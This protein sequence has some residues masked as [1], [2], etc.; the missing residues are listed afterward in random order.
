M[1]LSIITDSPKFLS[2]WLKPIS[3]K[4]NTDSQEE[5]GLFNPLVVLGLTEL[6]IS[7]GGGISGN[8]KLKLPSLL[9][10]AKG[11]ALAIAGWVH[12]YNSNSEAKRKKT[13]T[14][15]ALQTKRIAKVAETPSERVVQLE[16][17]QIGALIEDKNTAH[18]PVTNEEN[19]IKKSLEEIKLLEEKFD[20]EKIL[21]AI[22]KILNKCQRQQYKNIAEEAYLEIF[23]IGKKLPVRVLEKAL[24]DKDMKLKRW[25]ML[26]LLA[27]ENS[28][29]EE[30]LSKAIKQPENMAIIISFTTNE[31][32]EPLVARITQITKK[33]TA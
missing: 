26:C 14:E 10:G 33:D 2:W 32:L 23:E 9:I 28:E 25:T 22:R 8:E 7:I 16:G 12:I 18:V 15:Q 1:I 4:V 13:N 17:E 31:N 30:I 19:A 11:L 5:Q 21:S 3:S 20:I 27:K 24:E 29:A 6:G